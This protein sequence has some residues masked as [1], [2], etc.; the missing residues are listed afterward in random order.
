MRGNKKTDG[1]T[2][3]QTL[4]ADAL[5]QVRVRVAAGTEF[6]IIQIIDSRMV[7]WVLVNKVDQ[8]D[9][10][11]ANIENSHSKRMTGSDGRAWNS[12]SKYFV[13]EKKRAGGR[14][15]SNEMKK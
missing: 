9:P 15:V 10:L 12:N 1:L 14:A 3:S 7:M 11:Y 2:L 6:N 13:L 5:V 4:F 8:A